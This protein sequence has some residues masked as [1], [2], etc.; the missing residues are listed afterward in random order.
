MRSRRLKCLARQ[1]ID[2]I[3]AVLQGQGLTASRL[4]IGGD[5]FWTGKTGPAEWRVDGLVYD[6]KLKALEEG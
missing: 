5:Y 3:L 6:E 4:E 2:T 1:K